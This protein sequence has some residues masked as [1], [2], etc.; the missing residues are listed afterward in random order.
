MQWT[1]AQVRDTLSVLRERR[2]DSASIEVN[3]AAGGLPEDLPETLCAFANMPEGGTVIL[4]VDE[5][6]GFTVTGVIEPAVLEAGLVNQARDAVAPS[7]QVVSQVMTIDGKRIVVAEVR[8]LRIVDRP[9]A[10]SGVSYLRQSDGNYEIQEH[11]LRMIEIEKLH[12]VDRI[13]YDKRAVSDS[14]VD[15]LV[16]EARADYVNSTRTSVERLRT[17][18][19][20]DIL[21]LTSVVTASGA[22]TLAGLYALGDFPQGDEPSLTA[23]AA[24]QVPSDGSGIR[25]RNLRDFTGPIPILLDDLMTWVASN[26]PTVRRYREDGH[27]VEE[28]ELPLRAI[29]ELIANALVHR[30]LGPNTLGTGKGIQVRLND[31]AL[32][33]QSPGGLRGV[34]LRQI[35]SAEH[36]QAA[37]NQRLYN[38]AKRLRTADGSRVIE[39]EGGG[40]K[41]VFESAARAGLPRPTLIN[42]GVQFTAILWLPSRRGDRD[43][44]TG[45][46]Q[47]PGDL[48]STRVAQLIDER[49]GRGTRNEK[50]VLEALVG[51]SESTIHELVDRS[52]LSEAQLRYAL[53]PLIEDGVVAMRGRRGDRRTSYFLIAT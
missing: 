47:I 6:S 19:E 28:H 23:T 9:A 29:R 52:G 5:R 2:G 51:F 42:T 38:I 34:S 35:E 10:Y 4:G 30:D 20:D 53:K 16:A 43:T 39:G 31:R 44:P 45:G 25:N 1:E 36:A 49:K 27:M 7:P 48:A 18:S 21:R 41:E 26:V 32:V 40:I 11:E 8:P 13:E 33:I 46:S 22:L 24:V 3:R 17:R 12:S 15:D 50:R 37:V 14:R